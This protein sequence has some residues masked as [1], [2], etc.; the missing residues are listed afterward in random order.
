MSLPITS[1]NRDIKNYLVIAQFQF[2]LMVTHFLVCLVKIW[3][4]RAAPKVMPLILVCWITMSE[5]DVGGVAVVVEPSH[6]HPM[7]FCCCVTDGSRGAVWHN[8]VWRGSVYEAKGV[9]LNSSMW[10]KQYQLIF[11]DA[12]W[13]LKKTKQWMWA[14]WSRR[15]C[16]SAVVTAGHFCCCRFLQA[17]HAGSCSSLTKMHS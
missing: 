12:C 7:T 16:V 5:V 4:T 14:H 10:K 9:E 15:W 1:Y 11:L 17:Q 2:S 3:S 13:M 8:G 6:Q